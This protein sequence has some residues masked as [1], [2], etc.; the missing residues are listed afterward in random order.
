MELLVLRWNS[1]AQRQIKQVTMTPEFLW[2][3]YMPTL[4]FT[5][6]PVADVWEITQWMA[7]RQRQRF[8]AIAH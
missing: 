4:P 7:Q 1:Q 2:D 6:M 5:Q 3:G 8:L